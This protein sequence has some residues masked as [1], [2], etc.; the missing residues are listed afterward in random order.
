M[1]TLA[2]MVS[3]ERADDKK[4]QND[5]EKRATKRE[6]NDRITARRRANK[7]ITELR[8]LFDDSSIV[9][10][11]YSNET[12]YAGRKVLCEWVSFRYDGFVLTLSR[13][14]LGNPNLQLFKWGSDAHNMSESD[15]ER[16]VYYEPNPLKHS[17]IN[18]SRKTADLCEVE[19]KIDLKELAK[20]IA[21]V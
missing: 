10:D 8:R 18:I 1:A 4:K 11:E 20:A 14:Y 15:G 9:L 17:L 7:D 12:V 2:S 5:R 21:R 3:K 16:W 13:N 6:A 19:D